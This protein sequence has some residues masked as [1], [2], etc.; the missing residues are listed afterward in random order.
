M[1]RQPDFLAAEAT[2]PTELARRYLDQFCRHAAQAHRIGH[3]PRGHGA[4]P[5]TVRRA[6]A[7]ATVDFG[8][9]R[10]ILRA[11]NDALFLRAEAPDTEGLHQIQAIVG[12]DLGR[13]GHRDNLTVTWQPPQ[14]SHCGE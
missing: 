4:G 12:A 5:V 13:F 7:Q 6:G 11:G 8:R 2:V 14:P 1:T 10:C 3:R 9:G